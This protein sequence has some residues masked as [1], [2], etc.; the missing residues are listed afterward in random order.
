MPRYGNLAR[1][2][3]QDNQDRESKVSRFKLVAALMKQR[4][5]NYLDQLTRSKERCVLKSETQDSPQGLWRIDF[6][7]KTPQGLW[8]CG[9]AIE[10]RW[11]KAS[12]FKFVA[13]ISKLIHFKKIDKNIKTKIKGFEAPFR[14]VA[15]PELI[16]IGYDAGFGNGGSMGLGCVKKTII[17]Y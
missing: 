10:S 11:R 2:L 15:D 9:I 17:D 6:H 1:L 7:G 5:E 13:K 8:R 4:V 12:R 14:I 3:F 16:G